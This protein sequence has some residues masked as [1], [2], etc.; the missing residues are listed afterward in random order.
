MCIGGM[1][2]G[3]RKACSVV[4]LVAE[5]HLAAKLHHVAEILAATFD[6]EARGEAAGKHHA[7][8]E[9][10]VDQ[11]ADAAPD[12][13]VGRNLQPAPRLQVQKVLA[14]AKLQAELA[15]LVILMNHA[16]PA[17]ATA[18]HRRRPVQATR[19]RAV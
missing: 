8:E 10:D 13:A 14:V 3:Q 5:L 9:G 2:E 16:V 7:V 11:H 4:E 17:W 6:P 15:R 18:A 12:A 19:K 1:A